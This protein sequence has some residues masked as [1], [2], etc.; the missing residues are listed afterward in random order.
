MAANP[1]LERLHIVNLPVGTKAKL[2]KVSKKIKAK[3]LNTFI[4]DNLVNLTK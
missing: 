4:V 3:S 1:D 2:R